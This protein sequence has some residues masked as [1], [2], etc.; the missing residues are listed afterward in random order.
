MSNGGKFLVFLILVV[1]FTIGGLSFVYS[2]NPDIQSYIDSLIKGGGSSSS[3]SGSSQTDSSQSGSSQPGSSDG[4]GSASSSSP[5]SSSS[6]GGTSVASSSGGLE[7]ITIDYTGTGT[8]SS[9]GQKEYFTVNLNNATTGDE[10]MTVESSDATKVAVSSA[11]VSNG[12][13]IYA[14]AVSDFTESV[15]I[16]V[17]KE[18]DAAMSQTLAFTFEQNPI[19][20]YELTSAIMIADDQ[21]T[22]IECFNNSAAEFAGQ[23]TVGYVDVQKNPISGGG[24]RYVDYAVKKETDGSVT[25]EGSESALAGGRLGSVSVS[26]SIWAVSFSY[27]IKGTIE[28]SYP[29][30]ITGV[31]SYD[32]NGDAVFSP[33]T[34]TMNG[35]P[36]VQ[37]TSNGDQ[38]RYL[39]SYL[40]VDY[41]SHLG[42]SD[43]A[44]TSSGSSPNAKATM[45]RNAD[46]SLT[47]KLTMGF[48]FM[49]T[50]NDVKAGYDDGTGAGKGCCYS[51][52]FLN[53]GSLRSQIMFVGLNASGGAF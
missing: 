6:W 4:S 46:H 22:Q 21:S 53:F 30:G 28:S 44:W 10:Y 48:A 41:S 29:T 7:T 47:L 32:A 8:F 37:T 52:W 15:T 40:H 9:I 13:R 18:N 51:L 26:P 38:Y 17:A 5:S 1:P 16:T 23:N 11:T 39:G 20:S 25:S 24:I 49:K 42:E 35:R 36:F 12:A 2:S 50:I 14:S 19:A 3:Q 33:E 34:A 45:T 27:K 31:G 43:L